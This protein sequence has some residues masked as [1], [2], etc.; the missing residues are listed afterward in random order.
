M[1]IRRNHL[2]LRRVPCVAS[3]PCGRRCSQLW[4]PPRATSCGRPLPVGA[5]HLAPT[6]KH[7]DVD[8]AQALQALQGLSRGEPVEDA[9]LARLLR[10]LFQ[11]R[12]RKG[13]KRFRPFASFASFLGAQR[14]GSTYVKLG[15]FIAPTASAGRRCRCRKTSR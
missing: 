4:R 10:R 14:L 7:T 15:Q 9:P 8:S 6:H 1:C 5:S 13:R 12:G 11:R 2:L 3:K